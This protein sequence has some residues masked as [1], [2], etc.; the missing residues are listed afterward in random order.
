[1]ISEKMKVI[2]YYIKKELDKKMK[3]YDLTAVQFM[4]LSYLYDNQNQ[5]IIQKD[6]CNHLSLKHSTIINILKRLEIKKLITK[7]IIII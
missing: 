5:V 1:M 6:I 4:I 2:V 7:K 3:Q